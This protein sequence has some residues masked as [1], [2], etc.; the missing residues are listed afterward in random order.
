LGGVLGLER[1]T[2]ARE[3]EKKGS[4]VVNHHPTRGK[5]TNGKGNC[6]PKPV[7]AI[8]DSDGGKRRGNKG[9]QTKMLD[10][11]IERS[12][13]VLTERRGIRLLGD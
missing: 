7:R 10:S 8:K 11:L 13:N 4:G 6:N 2:G 12:L 9:D 3:G 5:N 1:K